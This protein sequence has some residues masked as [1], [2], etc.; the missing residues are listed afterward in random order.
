MAAGD[1]ELIAAAERTLRRGVSENISAQLSLGARYLGLK[2]FS[3]FRPVPLRVTHVSV[4]RRRVLAMLQRLY[5]F[6]QRT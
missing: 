4:G 1:A 5:T 2:T 6:V 3:I